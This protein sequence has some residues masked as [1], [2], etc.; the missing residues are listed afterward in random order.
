MCDVKAIMQFDIIYRYI[1]S[2][3]I[4]EARRDE[5]RFARRAGWGKGHRTS[6]GAKRIAFCT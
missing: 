4:R 3:I 5:K 2:T 1:G 6:L